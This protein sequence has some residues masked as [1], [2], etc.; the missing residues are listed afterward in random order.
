MHAHL[1]CAHGIHVSLNPSTG[2]VLACPIL[3]TCTTTQNKER[4]RKACTPKVTPTSTGQQKRTRTRTRGLLGTS[5]KRSTD[6]PVADAGN[7]SSHDR[8]YL[9][10]LDCNVPVSN[11]CRVQPVGKPIAS[12][13]SVAGQKR[14]GFPAKQRNS[15]MC[16]H[17]HRQHNSN[18]LGRQGAHSSQTVASRHRSDTALPCLGGP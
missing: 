7:I 2:H 1:L 17:G 14:E 8:L 4:K 6:R 18:E 10:T 13:L 16:A 12:K 11:S 5:V 15:R 3:V 9:P